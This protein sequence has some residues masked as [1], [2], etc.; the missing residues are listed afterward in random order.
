MKQQSNNEYEE[1]IY[2][3]SYKVKVF[4]IDGTLLNKFITFADAAR[5]YN[6]KYQETI[7]R[8]C[9]GKRKCTGRAKKDKLVW[10]YIND[11]FIL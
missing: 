3:I 1:D 10:R 7:V 5:F 4:N 2:E 8:C 11:N 6:I 9:D